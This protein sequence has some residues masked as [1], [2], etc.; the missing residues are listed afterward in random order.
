MKNQFLPVPVFAP[1]E[2]GSFTRFQFF[3]LMLSELLHLCV[4]CKYAYPK[5]ISQT[6]SVVSFTILPV[7]VA[8][9]LQLVPAVI[10]ASHVTK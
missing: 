4:G 2:R 1:T 5:R 10:F 6:A 7:K 8:H 9:I 3:L